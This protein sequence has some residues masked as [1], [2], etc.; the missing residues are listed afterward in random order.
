MAMCECS[1]RAESVYVESLFSIVCLS[2]RNEGA[3]LPSSY[4]CWRM[5]RNTGYKVVAQLG[6][7]TKF[8]TASIREYLGIQHVWDGLGVV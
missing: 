7:S 1:R 6:V 3:H 4:N 2:V 5:S 8:S